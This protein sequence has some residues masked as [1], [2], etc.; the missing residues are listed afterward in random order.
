MQA[1]NF[2]GIFD[3]FFAIFAD[4]AFFALFGASRATPNLCRGCLGEPQAKASVI[5]INASS[6]HDAKSQK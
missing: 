1:C 4:D 6:N 2:D 5:I 3:Q